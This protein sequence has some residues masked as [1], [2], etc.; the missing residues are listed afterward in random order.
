VKALKRRVF[1]VGVTKCAVMSGKTL[2]LIAVV[3]I[4]IVLATT[5]VSRNPRYTVDGFQ[6]SRI[7]M[8]D[9]GLSRGD[10]LVKAETF[11]LQTPVGQIARYREFFAVDIAHAPPAPGPIFRT[12]V[13]FPWLASLLY[14]WRGTT[15]LVDVS[16]AAYIA[17]V[18][19]MYWLLLTVARPWLAATGAALFAVSPLILGLGEADVTDMLALT[20]WIGALASVL[21]YMQAPRFAWLVSFGLATVLLTLTRQAVY[22]PIGAVAG[23]LIGARL[24]RDAIDTTRSAILA[25]VVGIVVVV[26]GIWYALMHGAGLAKELEIAHGLA[27]RNGSA[28][29]DEP[30]DTWYRHAVISDAV[31]A[32]KRALLDVLPVLALFAAASEIRRPET[33]ILIGAAVAGLAPLILDPT[34]SDLSRVLEA[35]LCPIVLAA[36]AMGGESLLQRRQLPSPVA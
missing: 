8:Q 2:W 33:A 13:L 30:F 18:L 11:Y 17:A 35:P 6:Y 34:S 12:R 26:N 20:L 16:H 29:P 1:A 21:H 28:R 25:A 3:V 14:R 9:A 32:G 36:L 24:R 5:V 4:A 7:A 23:A 19:L 27:V 31:A 22:L 15:S 10:A